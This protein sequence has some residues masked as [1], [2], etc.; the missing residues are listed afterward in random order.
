[1]EFQ[2]D[3]FLEEE[4]EG[5]TVSSKMKKAWAAQLEVLE[6][7]DRVCFEYGIQYF[8]AYGTLLGAVRHKGFIPWDD[9]IDIFMKRKDYERFWRVASK[10]L[11]SVY[12]TYNSH[13]KVL[14]E[15]CIFSRVVSGRCTRFDEEYLTKFHGFPYVAGIDIFPIDAYPVKEEE[16]T[17]ETSIV[18]SIEMLLD[19]MTYG[20]P[21]DSLEEG[22]KLIE[23]FCNVVLPRDLS[24]QLKLIE[25]EEALLTSYDIEE[26]GIKEI[27]PVFDRASKPIA[28]SCFDEVVMLPFENTELPAPV[29]YDAVLKGLYGEQY[30]IPIKESGHDYPFYKKQEEHFKEIHGFVPE[31]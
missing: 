1:M 7:I 21:I 10:G 19:Q 18:F 31:F 27:G 9:D 8:I 16:K 29:G 15:P 22:I 25:L 6:D 23:S 3:F 13:T 14:C 17:F 4:R 30:M 24:L 20:V 2:K 26:P 12:I 11:P 5:F 28:K